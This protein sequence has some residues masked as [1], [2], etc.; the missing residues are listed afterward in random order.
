MMFFSSSPGSMT[1]VSIG[2]ISRWLRK[3]QSLCHLLPRVHH[4]WVATSN[5]LKLWPSILCINILPTVVARAKDDPRRTP[6][7][8]GCVGNRV[9]S[10]SWR[11]SIVGRKLKIET[12]EI[13]LELRDREALASVMSQGSSVQGACLRSTP[14][15][16]R[17]R[18]TSGC[19][20]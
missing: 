14:R 10:D 5:I 18:A 17:P 11:D 2:S 20:V 16:R 1:E 15:R 12:D 9:Q 6:V 4:L 7:C 8:K 13:V 3:G 19:M